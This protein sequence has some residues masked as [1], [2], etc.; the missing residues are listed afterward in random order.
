MGQAT[1]APAQDMVRVKTMD[2]PVSATILV[3]IS[4][5]SV[6]FIVWPISL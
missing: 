3:V 1:A 2:G 6:V 4:V 5:D